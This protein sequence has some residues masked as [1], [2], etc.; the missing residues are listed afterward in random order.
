MDSRVRSYDE[1][2]LVARSDTEGRH[3]RGGQIHQPMPAPQSGLVRRPAPQPEGPR[4]RE[5]D[6]E[7]LFACVYEGLDVYARD[8][9]SL[10]SPR[11]VAGESSGELYNWEMDELG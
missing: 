8:L 6:D 11:M 7:G 4:P 1:G 2:E 3:T 9:W 10:I 5:L